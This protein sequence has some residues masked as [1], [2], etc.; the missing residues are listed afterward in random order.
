[1]GVWQGMA[2]E[3]L[4]F[5]PG[6]P[7]PNHVPPAGRP[8]LKQLLQGWSTCRAVN[9][10]PSFTHLDTPRRTP[11]VERDPVMNPYP[12]REST[13]DRIRICCRFLPLPVDSMIRETMLKT[14]ITKNTKYTKNTKNTKNTKY[15]RRGGQPPGGR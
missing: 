2:I 14:N 7:C 13:A 8:P 15:A 3:S 10:Q 6:L 4:K 9:R 5:Y 1:M 11:M 12:R